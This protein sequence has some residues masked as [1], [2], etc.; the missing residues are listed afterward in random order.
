MPDLDKAQ[1]VLVSPKRLEQSVNAVLARGL[2]EMRRATGLGLGPLLQERIWS[3]LGAEQDA[4]C[5]VDTEG[6]ESTEE[7]KRAERKE[8]Q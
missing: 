5:M 8:Q 3:K 2:G 6:T 4:Y 7:D 1:F